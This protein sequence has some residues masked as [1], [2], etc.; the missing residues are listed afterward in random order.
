MFEGFDAW[1]VELS[2]MMVTVDRARGR[3]SPLPA[4]APS[5]SAEIIHSCFVARASRLLHEGAS[6][7][8]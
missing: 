5:Y 8:Y 1:M 2:A 7:T 3:C 4:V 6:R